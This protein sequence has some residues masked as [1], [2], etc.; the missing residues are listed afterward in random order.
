MCR[1]LLHV[2]TGSQDFK[3]CGI[4]QTVLIRVVK[5]S[6]L[7]EIHMLKSIIYAAGDIIGRERDDHLPT[8]IICQENFFC[9]I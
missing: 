3:K 8:T 6:V 5:V 2:Y 4:Y 9:I 7:L 1:L